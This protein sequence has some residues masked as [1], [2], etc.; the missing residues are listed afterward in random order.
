MAA[1]LRNHPSTSSIT[2]AQHSIPRLSVIEQPG[3][4][5]EQEKSGN[6]VEF[7]RVAGVHGAISAMGFDGV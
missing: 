2:Y 5:M 7:L 6:E 3:V 1:P 4:Y